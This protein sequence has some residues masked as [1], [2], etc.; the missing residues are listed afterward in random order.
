MTNVAAPDWYRS[1]QT[2]D[3]AD[4]PKPEVLMLLA[5]RWWVRCHQTGE[6]PVPRLVQ[7]M[8]RAG[9]RDAAHSVDG[10]MGMVASTAR[11]PVDIRCSRCPAL[12]DDET[13]LLHAAMLTQWERADLAEHHLREHL[14]SGAGAAF[15]IGPLEGLGFLF[16]EAGLEF[17]RRRSAPGAAWVMPGDCSRTVH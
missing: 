17:G 9:V 12:S 10:L 11:R 2:R 3:V 14:L 5:M 1:D 16:L 15:A 7:A 4:L 8:R 13:V 6:D